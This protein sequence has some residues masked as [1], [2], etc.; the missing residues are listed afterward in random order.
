MPKLLIPILNLEFVQHFVVAVSSNARKAVG[1]STTRVRRSDLSIEAG[2]AAS[3]MTQWSYL[4]I[5]SDWVEGRVF[6]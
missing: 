3:N 2:L 1:G 6:A 5:E 4:F